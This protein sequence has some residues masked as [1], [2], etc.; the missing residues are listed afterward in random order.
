MD[1]L[2]KRTIVWP[3]CS[4]ATGLVLMAALSASPPVV[5]AADDPAAV[6]AKKSPDTPDSQDAEAKAKAEAE[7]KAK[8][9]AEARAKAEAAKVEAEAKAKAEADARAKA[10]AER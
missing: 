7:A 5:R 9:E 6:P 1:L 3:L 4:I 10:E 2:M 8:A